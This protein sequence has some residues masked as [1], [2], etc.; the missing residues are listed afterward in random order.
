M[1]IFFFKTLS[2]SIFS[3]VLQSEIQANSNSSQVLMYSL[4]PS[5]LYVFGIKISHLLT[6][7]KNLFY[8]ECFS[9]ITVQ[10]KP[11]FYPVLAITSFLTRFKELYFHKAVFSTS[12]DCLAGSDRVLSLFCGVT[13]SSS[14]ALVSFPGLCFDAEINRS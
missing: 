6:I 5:A 4:Q 8:V 2:N 1:L 13:S 3:Q 7:G 9:Q 14:L 11:R 12:L 10:V